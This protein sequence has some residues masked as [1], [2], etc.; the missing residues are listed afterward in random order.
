MAPSADAPLTAD[1]TAA[2]VPSSVG[3][4]RRAGFRAFRYILPRALDGVHPPAIAAPRG[5]A[6]L[7]VLEVAA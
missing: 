3:N 7:T 1:P 4:S 2:V 5:F 6:Y